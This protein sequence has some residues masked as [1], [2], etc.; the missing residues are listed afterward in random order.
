MCARDERTAT[1]KGQVLMFYPLER[2]SEKPYGGGGGG[3]L[4]W[5]TSSNYK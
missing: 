5:H 3:G 2:N 4:H 1:K